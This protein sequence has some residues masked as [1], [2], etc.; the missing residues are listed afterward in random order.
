MI[1]EMTIR[2]SREPDG[3]LR[4]KVYGFRWGRQMPYRWK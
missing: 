1:Y 4:L 3:Q 2:W